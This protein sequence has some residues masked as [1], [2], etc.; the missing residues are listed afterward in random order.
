M[1][2]PATLETARLRLR[3]PV[4]EDAAASFMA[5]AQDPEVARY[6]IW[7]PHASVETVRE[8]LQRCAGAWASGTAFAWAITAREDG[9][10]LGM[11]EVRMEGHRAELGYVLARPLWGRGFATEAV[12]A[13]V[14]AALAEPHLYRVWAVCDVENVA[15]VRVLEKAGMQREGLLRRWMVLPNLGEI[16]RD[17]WCYA[18][19]K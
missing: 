4:M 10:I 8:F 13:V 3:R 9:R 6:L 19:V 15:S 7:R 16:P 1:I 11:V 2:L 14:E 18:I 12:R 5:Y 17:C